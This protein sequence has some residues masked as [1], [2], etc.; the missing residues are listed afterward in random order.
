MPVPAGAATGQD[1]PVAGE[2]SSTDAGSDGAVAALAEALGSQPPASLR[3]ADPAAVATLATAVR[4]AHEHQEEQLVDATD[5][6]FEHIPRLL[7]GP[8]RRLLGGR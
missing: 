7:R 3:D 8:V 6:A 5:R 1:V 4:A 2:H